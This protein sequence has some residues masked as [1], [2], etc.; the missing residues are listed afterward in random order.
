MPKINGIA[1]QPVDTLNQSIFTVDSMIDRAWDNIPFVI[2]HSGMEVARVNLFWDYDQY[3]LLYDGEVDDNTAEIIKNKKVSIGVI[4]NKYKVFFDS[5]DDRIYEI[6][7]DFT[8]Y[9]LA[10]VDD[11]AVPSTSIKI[12]EN[13]I[14]EDL[15]KLEKELF[16]KE[17]VKT[18]ILSKINR[19]KVFEITPKVENEVLSKE[20]RSL[21]QET[22]TE[23]LSKKDEQKDV[24]YYM[25]Q[26]VP[27]TSENTE[28]FNLREEL[29]KLQQTYNGSNAIKRTFAITS[30]SFTNQF[31]LG[32][33]PKPVAIIN[34]IEPYL[35]RGRVLGKTAKWTVLPQ[36]EWADLTEGSTPTDATQTI[37][38]A[39]KDVKVALYR[40]SVTDLAKLSAD[41][42]NLVEALVQTAIETAPLKIEAD[43]ITEADN[44]S[45]IMYGD[46][47][48]SSDATVTS[49]M[50]LTVNALARLSRKFQETAKYTGDIVLLV[51]PKQ[52]EDLIASSDIKYAQ[53]FGEG[54]SLRG[55]P[56][57]LKVMN[58]LIFPS[59]KAPVLSGAGSGGIDLYNAIAFAIGS[60]GVAMSEIE[61][62]IFRDGNA[63]KDVI[64]VSKNIAVKG[65]DFN[66]I[67]ELHTA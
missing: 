25:S 37:T 15:T 38:E 7:E 3:A 29:M 32:V 33:Y 48:V 4:V 59:N 57:P 12:S 56:I 30:S 20:E 31:G 66:K 67:W 62:E 22:K 46:D 8:P 55:I 54:N 11:P 23:E 64:T 36:A 10:V 44:T 19:E 60:I 14:K 2:S 9:E 39:T 49:S 13:A 17:E 65:L 27:I 21:E 40:Q 5:T 1:L 45:N 63:L 53:N 16:V 18:I 34:D 52:F 26:K 24:I 51:H 50:V 42:F 58:F 35:V 28:E 61:V 41:G 43:V 47:S 6:I